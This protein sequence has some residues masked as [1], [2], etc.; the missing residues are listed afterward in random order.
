[1][2]YYSM[3]LF[4]WD[5]VIED[6]ATESDAGP[7]CDKVEWLH[8]KALE[9]AAFHLGVGDTEDEPLP[10]TK[11]CTLFRHAADRL[12]EDMDL[13]QRRAFLGEIGFY[14]GCCE[15][16][17]D[18]VRAGGLPSIEAFWSH[19][20]GTSSVYTYNALGE[21]M[22]GGKIPEE[23]FRTEELKIIWNE[24]NCHIFM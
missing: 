14:M 23:L 4:L 11:Y 22:I 18:Y 24:L 5:D 1:M 19:R 2:A 16:E 21:Y 17:Q 9:Y 7:D 3:W 10:P 8:T 12:R 15:I 13:D 6:K 20:L